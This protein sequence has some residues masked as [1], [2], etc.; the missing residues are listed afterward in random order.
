MNAHSREYKHTFLDCQDCSVFLLLHSL[1]SLRMPVKEISNA[2]V[3]SKY[4]VKTS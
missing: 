4:A 2:N 3:S 1:N